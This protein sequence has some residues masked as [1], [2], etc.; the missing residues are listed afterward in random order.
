MEDDER[1]FMNNPL[2]A[3]FIQ[4]QEIIEILKKITQEIDNNDESFDNLNSLDDFPGD[5]DGN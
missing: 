4:N 5:E 2:K 1:L 3:L